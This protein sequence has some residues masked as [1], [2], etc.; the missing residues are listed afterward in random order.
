MRN[1]P[2]TLLTQNSELR[3]VGVYNWTLPAHVVTRANGQRFNVC[4]NAGACGRVCYAK[5]GMY[6]FSNVRDRH[7]RNLEYVLTD[8]YRWEHQML[9]ET[10][11]TR[12]HPTGRRHKLDHDPA[13]TFLAKWIGAGGK[14]VR[15][16]DAGD[17]YDAE[18]LA[19]W[20]RIASR[21]PHVL[22]YAYTKEVAMLKATALPTNFRVVYSL[23]GRQDHLVDKAY[24]RHADVFPTEQ[25][26]R[27]AGYY[28]QEDNDLLAV[29]AP[30]A[31]IGIVQNNLPVTIKRFDGRAMSELAPTRNQ[32]TGVQ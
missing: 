20:V 6:T 1:A 19:R 25:A 30:T 14:A 18:Y 28:N 4:P 23:G 27:T 29:T 31:R 9:R 3:Q 12:F 22:F 21:R 24:D 13:D 32:S 15:I 11:H 8:G 7:L 5:F 16:H 10:A 26:L 17:F 2:E